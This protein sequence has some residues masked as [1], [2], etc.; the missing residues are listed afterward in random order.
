MGRFLFNNYS[1][2]IEPSN[3]NYTAKNTNTKEVVIVLTYIGSSTCPFCRS[4]IVDSTLSVVANEITE[5]SA[6]NNISHNFI[7][8]SNDR[9]TIDGV[10]HLFNLTVDF[11]EIATGNNWMN[12]GLYR[13]TN[14]FKSQ[15]ATPQIVFS[16]R[17]YQDFL[18]IGP[19]NSI[20]EE[21]IMGRFIGLDAFEKIDT[22][23][24]LI[25]SFKD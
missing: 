4:P 22:K 17:I 16:K 15:F 13:Y 20:K 5:F 7:G 3:A 19:W 24:L 9:N 12:T 1:V 2:I 11:H 18:S 23:D 25:R 21:K 6:N 10:K 14:T 8:L